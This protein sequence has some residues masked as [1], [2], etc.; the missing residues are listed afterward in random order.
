MQLQELWDHCKKEL[1][2]KLG[3][4]NYAS[5]VA[6][7]SP[8]DYKN[9]ELS[10]L[11]PSSFV[12]NWLEKN[13]LSEILYLIDSNTKCKNRIRFIIDPSKPK[14]VHVSAPVVMQKKKNIAVQ[15]HFQP[16]YT[17]NT[18]VVGKCNEFA[19][20]SSLQCSK[21]PGTKYNPLFLYGGVGL[22]KTHLMQAI[23]RYVIEKNP[24]SH[25]LF[26][27]SEQFVNQMISALKNGQMERFRSKYRSLDVLLVDDIQ[28]IA[29]KDR[30]QEEFF[31]TFNTL[32]ETGKQIVV[33]SDQ[34]PKEI[35]KLEER[36][37]SRFEWGLIADI[38]PADLETKIAIV[39]K[40]ADLNDYKIP[41]DVAE[42]LA[43]TI[44]SNIRELEGCLARVVAYASLSGKPITLELAKET[45]RGVYSEAMKNIDIQTIQKAVA[46]H[47]SLKISELKSNN[48]A[49]RI[50][51]PR[52]IAMY[53]CREF[54]DESLPEIG[55]TFGGRDHSTVIHAYKKV[56]R[57]M[58]VNTR[59][60]NDLTAVKKSLGL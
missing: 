24:N 52:H 27:S 20:A 33:S 35:K 43:G 47:F 7:T 22:G 42:Y 16:H 39:N 57:D 15:P 8:V 31:H 23:G 21:N 44:K 49:K 58:E 56:K 26:L 34:Y 10:I 41:P 1:E 17:F 36:L 40:K 5:Y 60:Y 30:S 51:V 32:F 6:P 59:V 45:L 13:H 38:K 12:A 9:N 53:L 14:K 50:V 28:F 48:R 4:P 46:E 55:R 37:K 18:F 3:H 29:G 2:K 54:T 19:Y 11:V 25:V